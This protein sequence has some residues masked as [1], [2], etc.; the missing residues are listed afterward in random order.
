MEDIKC[1]VPYLQTLSYNS[2]CVLIIC[3]TPSHHII[4][5]AVQ[6]PPHFILGW[7]LLWLPWGSVTCAITLSWWWEGGSS[8]WQLTPHT[9]T[10]I[11]LDHYVHRQLAMFLLTACVYISLLLFILHIK[12]CHFTVILGHISYNLLFLSVRNVTYA[13]STISYQ[14]AMQI[15]FVYKH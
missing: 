13:H 14:E 12:C 10:F 11:L 3:Y 4:L 9:V 1:R 7:P 8:S 6:L 15:Y 5:M 2:V